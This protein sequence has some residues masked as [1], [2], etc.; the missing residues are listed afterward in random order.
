MDLERVTIPPLLSTIT[1]PSDLRKLTS[2]QLVHLAAEIRE[3][4]V[5]SVARTGGHLGPNLGVVELTI[6]LHRVF[7][8]PVDTIVWDTGHQAYVH[9]LLTGRQDLADLRSKNGLSGYPARAESK[10]DVVENSHAS[11][12]LSWADGISKQKK[13]AN[14]PGST[15]AVIGDGALTGGMAWEALN[16]IA[17][18]K[19]RSLVIV[20]NDNGRSYEPTIGGLAQHLDALRTSH[21]YERVLQWGKD[22]LLERGEPGKAM[23]GALH[24]LKTGIKDVLMPGSMFDE[25]GLKYIGAIDGHDEVAVELALTRAKG[26]GQP[27]LVHVITQKGRG[28]VPAEENTADRFHAVGRIHPET[29]LPVVPQRFGWTTVFAEEIVNQAAQNPDIVGITAAMMEPVGLKPFKE[30]FPNRVFDVG[31]AEQHALTAAAGM[32]FQGA[33]PFVAVYSTFLNRAW[34]QMLLDVA[35]HQAPVTIVLDRAGITGDDGPSHNGMW[36]LSLAA[37]VPG[38]RVNAPRDAHTLRQAIR[39]AA[40]IEDGPTLI[41]YPKGEPPKPMPAISQIGGAD[42]LYEHLGQSTGDEPVERVLIISCGVLAVEALAA[43]KQLP[44]VSVTVVDPRWVLP[45]SKEL[46]ALAQNFD[47]V[48]TVEDGLEVGGVGSEICRL[49]SQSFGVYDDFVDESTRRLVP[50]VENESVEKRAEPLPVPP[51]TLVLGIPRE[52]LQHAKRTDILHR[53]GLDAAGIIRRIREI[54]FL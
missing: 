36:D 51:R 52:F 15:V 8:S 33:H 37:M 9:K 19:E 13:L 24:G 5:Q 46:V 20:I 10:H 28:Y 14:L 31:I 12:S 7:E 41:R 29:G 2:V 44:Q 11:T 43:A 38:L 21:K 32:A 35:L 6:A 42:M 39:E 40:A 47:L 48:V 50:V 22:R 54:L 26:L 23:F 34:D 3:Y 30:H 17:E 45:V 53:L 16:N 4:L 49:L 27:V 25:L 1:E 18:D